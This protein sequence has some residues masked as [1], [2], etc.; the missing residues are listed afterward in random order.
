M[1][2]LL[3]VALA[4]QIQV[5]GRVRRDTT[6]SAAKAGVNAEMNVGSTSASRR[7][8]PPKRIPVTAEHLR[9]AFKTPLA[10]TLLERARASRMSQDSA[11]TSYDATAYIRISAGM[12]FS[13]IGR[14]RLIFRHENVTHVKW[15][16]DIGGGG[17]RNGAG[18]GV[19]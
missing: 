12:G 14:D 17:G 8:R 13:K 2:A 4:L 5:D 18:T 1:P 11:L 19:S 15:H 10:R 9:S 7:R 6:D 16:R 3:L